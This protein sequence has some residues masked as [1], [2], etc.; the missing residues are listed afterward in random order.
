[1]AGRMLL[2]AHAK[3]GPVNFRPA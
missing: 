2:M 1:M 3:V